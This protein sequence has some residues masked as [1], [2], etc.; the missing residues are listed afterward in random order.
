MNEELEILLWY[1]S[2]GL[3]LGAILDRF[4]IVSKSIGICILVL[5]S[6]FL[7]WLIVDTK[8]IM[9]KQKNKTFI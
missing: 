3:L 4:Y 7:V 5:L 8:R 1:M 6:I 9:V 2:F